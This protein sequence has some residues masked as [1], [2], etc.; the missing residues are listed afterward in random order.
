MDTGYFCCNDLVDLVAQP[1]RP[2]WLTIH[3]GVD[4]AFGPRDSLPLTR[5]LCSDCG[6]VQCQRPQPVPLVG[7]RCS[8]G[9]LWAKQHECAREKHACLQDATPATIPEAWPSFVHTS[10][11]LF[12]SNSSFLVSFFSLSILF[13]FISV[14]CLAFRLSAS[15]LY[16]SRAHPS[17]PAAA[18]HTSTAPPGKVSAAASSSHSHLRAAVLF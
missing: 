15:C 17:P 7:C 14:V 11:S 2:S 18:P 16:P 13:V 8:R 12:P 4:L 6:A 5:S 9:A 3:P 1:P 10:S